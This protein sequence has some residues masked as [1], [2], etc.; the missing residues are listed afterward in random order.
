M[1]KKRLNGWIIAFYTVILVG[2]TMSAIGVKQGLDQR[3]A[4]GETGAPISETVQL[5]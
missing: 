3:A 4:L 2:T 1:E 5:N